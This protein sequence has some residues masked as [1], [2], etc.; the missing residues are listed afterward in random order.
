MCFIIGYGYLCRDEKHG[1]IYNKLNLLL[2]FC[3]KCCARVYF[4]IKFYIGL[5][6]NR[7]IEKE[8]VYITK[9]GKFDA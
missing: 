1:K 7:S 9:G 6:L 2:M 5:F 4:M 8:M 3:Q